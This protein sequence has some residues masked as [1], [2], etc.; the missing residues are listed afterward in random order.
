MTQIIDQL[1][2]LLSTDWFAEKWYLFGMR[3]DLPAREAMRQKCRAIVSQL[4]DGEID[5]WL[6]SFDDTRIRST[7][8]SFFA[9]A[10]DSGLHASDVEFL[11]QIADQTPAEVKESE[12]TAL[13]K[14]LTDL[15]VSDSSPDVA[16]N[17]TGKVIAT[18]ISTY[19]ATSVIDVDFVAR[20]LNS[21]TDW[22]IKLRNMTSGL[23]EYLADFAT[24]ICEQ[25]HHFVQFW[26]RLVER[27]SENERKGLLQWYENT[28]LEL[29]KRSLEF[30]SWMK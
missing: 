14:S 28:A 2:M 20:C 26:A 30:P 9:A 12:N 22:D 15:L 7:Y 19:A 11:R 8:T 16:K 4:F 29:T 5:Y 17:L 6:I 21:N 25:R 10:I 27:I 1:A 24:D 18:V 23:P 13:L 3:S